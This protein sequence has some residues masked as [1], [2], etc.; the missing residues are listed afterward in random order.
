MFVPA[1]VQHRFESFSSDLALWAVFVGDAG[2][3]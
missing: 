2:P 1:G 3:A